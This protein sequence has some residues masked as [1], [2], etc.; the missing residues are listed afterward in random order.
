MCIQKQRKSMFLKIDWHIWWEL[1][2][3]LLWNSHLEAAT[4][5]GRTGIAIEDINKSW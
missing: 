4:E 5:L 3:F 1:E 2:K